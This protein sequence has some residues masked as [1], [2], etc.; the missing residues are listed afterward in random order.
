MNN[1][2]NTRAADIVTTGE[3]LVVVL[4]VGLAVVVVPGFEVVVVISF[5][6]HL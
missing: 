6:L 2:P 3:L 1:I 5:L 4:A